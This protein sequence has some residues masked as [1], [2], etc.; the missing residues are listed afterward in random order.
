M[1]D[2]RP[3][4]IFD[5]G[6][7]GL[8]AVKE[9]RKLL[10][11]EDIVYF[12][13][14][15]RVPYGSKSPETIIKYAKEDVRFLKSRGVKLIVAACGTVSAV[16]LDE[17]KKSVDVPLFGVVDDAAAEAAKA[18]KNGIIA[19]IGTQ[20]TIKSRVFERKLNGKCSKVITRACP[21]FVSLVECGFTSVDNEVLRGV[22][23]TYLSDIKA[24]GADTL[25]LGC[26]HF[27]IISDAISDFLPGVTLI[28]PSEATAR[29]IAKYVNDSGIASCT[30]SK[31]E[32]F[33]S[34]DE[35]SFSSSAG[36]FLGSSDN[37][38]ATAVNIN[39]QEV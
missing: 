20:A 28:N 3:I 25:I 12:G 23:K 8:S 5:S 10:P 18:T 36:V 7:G 1:N 27:P 17:I 16:A 2:R 9:I 31:T 11:H 34:D 4:G 19:V 26:T 22:C 35:K 33:V 39:D 14:T 13:D 32:Y 15:G 21:L 38:Y 6:L 24:S 30:G 29:S 37:V